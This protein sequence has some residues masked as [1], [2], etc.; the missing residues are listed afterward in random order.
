MGSCN[1]YTLIKEFIKEIEKKTL[2]HYTI[3]FRLF[4]FQVAR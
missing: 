3:F 4:V 1:L 2:F